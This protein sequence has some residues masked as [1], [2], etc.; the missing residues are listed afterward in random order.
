MTLSYCLSPL[1]PDRWHETYPMAKGNNQSPVAI[2]TKDV[3]KDPALLPWFTGY[4]PGAAKTIMNTGK[5]CRVT[6]DDTFDRSGNFEFYLLQI[7][8]VNQYAPLQNEV[9]KGSF[10]LLISFW[11]EVAETLCYF[12]LFAC[13]G[14][15]QCIYLFALLIYSGRA[16]L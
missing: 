8:L 1:G 11:G 6:F 15:K 7:L 2:L 12:I 5:T 14:L 3:Y 16:V 9:R 10:K 4:D 13:R